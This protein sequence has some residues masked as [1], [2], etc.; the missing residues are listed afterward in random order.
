MPNQMISFG[1]TH[2]CLQK[3]TRFQWSNNYDWVACQDFCIQENY[4]CVVCNDVF[5][6]W[7]RPQYLNLISQRKTLLLQIGSERKF[8]HSNI[9]TSGTFISDS[10]VWDALNDDVFYTYKII[11]LQYVYFFNAYFSAAFKQQ[12][13][14]SIFLLAWLQWLLLVSLIPYRLDYACS[15]RWLYRFAFCARCFL[16]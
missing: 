3:S 9:Q 13:T 7:M 4:L 5:S 12:Q 14:S 10:F 6:I 1:G 11:R 16:P 8:S 2:F 15:F